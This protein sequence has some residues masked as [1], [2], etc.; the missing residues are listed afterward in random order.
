MT[1]LKKYWIWYTIAVVV[2]VAGILAYFNWETVKGWF[3][4]SEQTP[5]TQSQDQDSSVNFPAVPDGVF[6][7]NDSIRQSAPAPVSGY[8][9]CASHSLSFTKDVDP[10][11]AQNFLDQLQAEFNMIAAKGIKILLKVTIV[12]NSIAA[13]SIITFTVY[14]EDCNLDIVKKASAYI[15]SIH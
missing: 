10:I 15:N 6:I 5:G 8:K 9:I 11:K 4:S 13:G 1:H 2:I 12:P 7:S 3:G 14:A